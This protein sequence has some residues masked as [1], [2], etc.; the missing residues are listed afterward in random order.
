MTNWNELQQS[1]S[2]AISGLPER[3][4]V[5]VSRQDPEVRMQFAVLDG[6]LRTEVCSDSPEDEP[7]LRERGWELSDAWSG[8]WVREIPWPAS[9]ED[10]AKEVAEASYA[11]RGVWGQ[12]RLDSFGY[13][14]WQEAEDA[15]SWMFW[16]SSK[17]RVLTMDELGLPQRTPVV[18]K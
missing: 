11:L 17:D 6:S 18:D 13:H 14:A 12:A 9:R 1:L 16:K 7:K 10:I 15:P 4:A 3:G 5:L 2:T 8:V